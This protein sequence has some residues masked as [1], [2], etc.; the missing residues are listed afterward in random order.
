MG[1]T[2]T[3]APTHSNQPEWH[4]GGHLPGSGRWSAH[5]DY[6]WQCACGNRYSYGTLAINYQHAAHLREDPR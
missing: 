4:S 5:T 2:T 6:R 1:M 3:T